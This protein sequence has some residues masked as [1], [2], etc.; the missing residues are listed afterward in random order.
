MPA[1]DLARLRKQAA[2]LAEFFFLPD[3]FLK[4]LHEM[5]EFYV[6]RSL[7]KVDNVAPGSV[8]STYRT[9][10]IV[11]RQIELE[12]SDIAADNPAQALDLADLLWDQGYLEMH[13]LAAFL[14]G[15]IPP[16]GE[17]QGPL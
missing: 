7:R 6:N 8:L 5:L 15:R 11:I 16:H 12:L 1:I 9:P 2:R 17:R 10:P 14:L 13:M 3:E 4:H